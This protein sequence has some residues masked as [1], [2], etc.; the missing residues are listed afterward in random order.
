[1]VKTTLEDLVQSPN[2]AIRLSRNTRENN[3][4]IE[5]FVIILNNREL[6]LDLMSISCRYTYRSS[7]FIVSYIFSGFIYT[8]AKTSSTK[9]AAG[10]QRI[11]QG[12]DLFTVQVLYFIVK[13]LTNPARVTRI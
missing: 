11:Q 8:Q 6:Q 5:E 3:T 1:M 12:T 9:N 10:E 4:Y 2:Q 13:I 7:F